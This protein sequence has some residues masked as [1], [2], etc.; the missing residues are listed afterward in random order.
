MHLFFV[1]SAPP[2]PGFYAVKIVRGGPRVGAKIE[3]GPGTDPETGEAL[4]R[5]WMWSAW[6]DGKL[7][8]PPSPD[9]MVA[10]CY[11]ISVFGQ[12]ISE[13]DYLLLVKTGEWAKQH[14]PT[15]PAANPNQPI[16]LLTAPLP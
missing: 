9:P 8:E 2:I 1:P 15:D 5:S 3:H 12:S 4:D 16:N 7:V 14:S 10:G 13:A 11:R 6:I